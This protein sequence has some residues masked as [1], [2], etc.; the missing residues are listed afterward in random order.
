MDN[1]VGDL[2]SEQVRD[3]RRAPARHLQHI[4]RRIVYESTSELH[5]VRIEQAHAVAAAEIA[6]NLADARRQQ[7]TALVA[8]RLGRTAIDAERSRGTKRECYPMLSALEPDSGRDDQRAGLS[9]RIERNRDHAR[10][11]AL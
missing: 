8:Q 4:R 7:R 3:F 2:V 1:L 6:A 9:R 11:A 5:A 10:L